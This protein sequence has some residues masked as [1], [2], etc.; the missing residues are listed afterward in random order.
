MEKAGK[1]DKPK[2][3]PCCKQLQRL[4]A[5]FSGMLPVHPPGPR[6][7]SA[8]H[9]RY[10]KTLRQ[11]KIVFTELADLTWLDKLWLGL[12]GWLEWS[13]G[14]DSDDATNKQENDSKSQLKLNLATGLDILA[15][16]KRLRTLVV[17][18]QGQKMTLEDAKWMREH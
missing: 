16:L 8:D 2:P 10:R 17:V 1:N 11:H 13:N 9:K 7:T 14:E 4:H 6:A 18:G 12:P 5:H 15:G 3:W